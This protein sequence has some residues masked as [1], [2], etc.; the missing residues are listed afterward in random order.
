MREVRVSGPRRPVTGLGHRRE[1]ACH[2]C[3]RLVA[4]W[5]SQGKGGRIRSHWL[6]VAALVCLVVAAPFE[7]L[8]AQQV[9]GQGGETI[10][11]L[12]DAASLEA[13]GALEDAEEVLL[14]VLE[15]EPASLNAILLLER[16]LRAQRRLDHILPTVDRLLEEDPGSSVGRQL[17]LR[18]LSHL[19]ELEAL[20]SAAGAW[21]AHSPG[22]ET[23]YREIA[24][25]WQERGDLERAWAVLEEGRA[26]L[27]REDALALELGTIHVERG[28]VD[29]AVQEWDRAIGPEA[30]GLS[31]VLRRLNRLS[32]GGARLL[33]SLVD[34]L[35]RSPTS[36]PRQR[37]AVELALN[38][39]L[40]ARAEAV[41]REL[42]SA[43]SETERPGF[44]IDVA[45]RAD[46]ARLRGLAYWAYTGLLEERRERSEQEADERDGARGTRGSAE[47]LAVRARLGELA[48][49]LGDTA[50]ARDHYR[51]V[52]E[53]YDAG[54]PE[55]R[56]A[57]A[58]RIE[59][60]AQGG[61]LDEA[62][63]DLAEFRREFPEAPEIDG[64]VAILG[65]ALVARGDV[66][67]TDRLTAGVDGPRTT[68]LR[69][70]RALRE[71]DLSAARSAFLS[72]A[73]R[74]EGQEA[75][76]VIALASLL[77]RLSPEGGRRL[78]RA[79]GLREVEDAATAVA[80][81][82]DGL[83]EL[84]RSER[85]ALLDHAAGVADRNGEPAEAERIRR[86]IIV[87]YP[88][89]REAPGAFLALA[90]TLARRRG[91][92]GEALELLERLILDYPRSA[93]IPQA[94]REFERLGGR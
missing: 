28:A 69:A 91:G 46:G 43:L 22:I 66:E 61:R 76:E 52:E 90:R 82:L 79:M 70:R 12:R 16:V 92:E 81:L 24:R 47:L 57:A 67:A 37:A 73:P 89:M 93:L 63:E 26:R 41:A 72:A 84:E 55:R 64:L 77:G 34:A 23:A 30:R 6:V 27:D 33:P 45:R 58:L 15:R 38:A 10:E 51:I 4:G 32:D 39:G 94:R 80:D 20:E 40:E 29:E 54:S 49:A 86:T 71:G 7:R 56:Q 3:M 60:M 85:A 21:I 65:E 13:A 19:D 88:D 2:R 9:K 17:Q 75:T 87:D 35:T 8:H 25:V 74:L 14:L 31:P 42:V 44:L 18:T 50:A 36:L 78:G 11:L 83:D 68:L 59:L 48:L 5:V 1:D 62:L 53:A